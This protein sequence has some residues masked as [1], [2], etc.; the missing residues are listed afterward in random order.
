MADAEAQDEEEKPLTKKQK[1]K[2]KK[3]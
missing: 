1:N 3:K 2:L